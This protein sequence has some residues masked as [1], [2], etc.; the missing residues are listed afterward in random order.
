M[1]KIGLRTPDGDEMIVHP[2]EECTHGVYLAA[3][4]VKG[5]IIDA[6]ILTEYDSTA[7]QEGGT[8]R[9]VDYEYRDI[10]LGFHVVDDVTTA[11]EADSMLAM[12]FDSEPDEW[13]PNPQRCTVLDFTTDISGTRHL[14]LLIAETTEYE[15]T[16]DPES[17][18]YFNPQYHLR[19]GQPMYYEPTK[20]SAY[21]FGSGSHTGSFATPG[22]GPG[23]WVENRTDRAMRHTWIVSG[24]IGTKVWLP[25]VSWVGPKGKRQIAG[26]HPTRMVQLPTIAAAH[27]GGFKVTLE[28][29]KLMVRDKGNTNALGQMPVPG[30]YF[31][32]RIPPYTRKTWLPLNIENAPA[33]GGRIELHMPQ[34]WS[35]PFGK[36]MW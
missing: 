2:K 10:H 11:A 22:V 24:G 31:M 29:G 33:E 4:Q 25:D 8:Q 14:D 16:T 21:D 32:Y 7:L 6:P 3:E 34:L 23:V 17:N 19:A 9:G 13:D 15:F 27:Q 30:S 26:P 36:E 5:D 28:R 20:I 35:R 1:W 12:K 18:E